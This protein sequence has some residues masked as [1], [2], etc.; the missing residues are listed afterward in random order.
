MT[1]AETRNSNMSGHRSP[2]PAR[3]RF[4]RGA[5]LVFANKQELLVFA[6]K[7]E[8]SA[9]PVSQAN[10]HYELPCGAPLLRARSCPEA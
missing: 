4:P 2:G 1:T 6:N 3:G 5:R 8:Q 7:Q 9:A 10:E